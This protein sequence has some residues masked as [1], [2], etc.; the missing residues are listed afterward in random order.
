M[1]EGKL[2]LQ[3]RI[4]NIEAHSILEAKINVQIKIFLNFERKSNYKQLIL[5][6]KKYRV[7]Q[8]QETA[9][10]IIKGVYEALVGMETKLSYVFNCSE[11]KRRI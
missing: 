8:L 2:F 9:T 4:Q 10:D 11:A 3:K 1:I 6:P 7:R 5:S